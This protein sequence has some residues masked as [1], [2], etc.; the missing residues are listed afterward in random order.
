[1]PTYY[2]PSGN[3]EVWAEKPAGYMTPEEWQ[4]AHPA[5]EPTPLTEAEPFAALRAGRDRRLAET[6]YMVMPD[7]PIEADKLDAVKVYRQA[8]RDIPAQ[9]GAPWDGGGELTPWPEQP[10]EPAIQK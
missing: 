4:T 3:P 6:D 7:Y 9:P 2:S 1:M 10:M 5:P 8:L